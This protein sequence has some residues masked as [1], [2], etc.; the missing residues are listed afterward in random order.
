MS[1]SKT[2]VARQF[3][4]MTR[5]RVEGLLSAFP[6]LIDAGRDHTFIET[7]TVRYLYQ[8]MES[9]HLLIVTNKTSNIL[10]DLETLRLMA[11]VVQDCCQIQVNEEMVIKH[12]FDIVF[13]FDEV[14]SFGHRESVTL[15]QIKSYTEMDSHEEKLHQM[16]EQSKI[17]EAREMAKKKQLELKKQRMQDGNQPKMEG[18]G[19]GGPSSGGNDAP[20]P[21]SANP[22]QSTMSSSGGGGNATSFGGGGS[23]GGMSMQDTPVWSPSMNDDSVNIIQPKAGPKKGMALGKKKPGDIFGGPDPTPMP[24][25]VQEEAPP[26]PVHNPLLEPVKVDIEEKITADLQV[27]GGLEGDATCVGQFQVTVLDANK[28]DLVCFKLAPQSQEFKY[29]VHPNLNKASQAANVLEVRDASKAFRAN[30]PAPLLKWQS[31]SSDDEFLPV[32]LS[33]WPTSTAEGTQMVLELELT[34][35]NVSLEDVY[36]RFPASA[37]ARP[38][39]ASAS[40]G[41]AGYDAGAG[42][43]VWR[44][45]VLDSSEGTGTLEFS[46]AA[47]S[48]SL[49]P[50]TFEAVRR[51]STKCPMDI[52]ECYHQERK[53]AIDFLCQKSCVYSLRIG[54]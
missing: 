41:E 40:P 27:E 48:A 37:S 19:G 23:G 8:P 44:I 10:E 50:A 32:T 6:K 46:A 24:E 18:F 34:D 35:S 28:A 2:L 16:I 25:D 36:I 26:A 12:A 4:E 3:V 13:A 20:S 31:K 14:I 29:K 11:K 33:C 39:I 22:F 1:G 47:D 45:P 9:L 38:S 54:S 15:A 52:L 53:D 17:N 51:G 7:E 43:V 49:L 21:S 30:Q 42:Q 5:L